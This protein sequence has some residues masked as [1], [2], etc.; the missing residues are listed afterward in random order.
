MAAGI[1][2]I[3]LGA[4][5]FLVIR[6]LKGVSDNRKRLGKVVGLACLALGLILLFSS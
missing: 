1:F 2:F 3:A 5:E 6:R 4:L